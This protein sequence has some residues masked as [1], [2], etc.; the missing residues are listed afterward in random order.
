MTLKQQENDVRFIE[1]KSSAEEKAAHQAA[2][3]L[4]NRLRQMERACVLEAMRREEG[5]KFR[6][7]IKRAIANESYAVDV[8]QVDNDQTAIQPTSPYA[9]RMKH[10]TKA[11]NQAL[12]FFAAWNW[13]KANEAANAQIA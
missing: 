4:F 7:E 12:Q 8:H 6:E 3:A 5:K 11:V 1:V 2:A 10:C 13:M 9:F